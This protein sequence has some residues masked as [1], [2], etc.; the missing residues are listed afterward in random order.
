MAKYVL[1]MTWSAK[2]VAPA[3]EVLIALGG[4]PAPGDK[5]E[6]RKALIET[7]LEALEPADSGK[8]CELVWT[9]GETDMVAIIEAADNE[10]IGGFSLYLNQVHGV[11]T[12]TLPA[13]E[14]ESMNII[15]K[16]AARCGQAT[17]AASG[18]G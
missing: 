10:S 14:P 9:L 3:Q 15:G 13:F 11:R 4:S 8:L 12:T 7:A 16:I 1:L 2:A 18:G 17:K 6:D 5:F